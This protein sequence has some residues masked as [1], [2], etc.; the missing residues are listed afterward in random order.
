MSASATGAVLLLD[1]PDAHLEVLRQRQIYQILAQTAAETQ[2][3]IIAASHS[4]VILNEAA[5][6]D[7]VVAFIGK[8]HRIDDRGK[9]LVKAL[10]EIGFEQYVQA[11]QA[12]WVLYL[13]GSTD[14]AILQA[15]A[16]K[17]EHPARAVLERPFAH[18][19]A[20]QPGQA[21]HHFY[22]LRE[23]KPDLAGIALYDRLDLN[24]LPDPELSQQMWR[25]RE[26]ESYLC[27]RSTLVNFAKSKGA[28]QQGDLFAPLWVEAME[29]SIT[30]IAAALSSLGKADP[31]GPDLKVSDDFLRPLF[32]KFYS[33][34]K[35]PDLLRKTD[36][37]TLAP[38][39]L[40][41]EVDPEVGEK[42]DAIAAVASKAR[43]RG[44]EE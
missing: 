22:A 26:I 13:E 15:F 28:E 25:R 21:R 27:H 29:E 18:Y 31:W 6:R 19:V 4:E 43:P 9:Q 3:Q 12:G 32:Q 17:L 16:E 14:L 36:Y 5:D 41:A 39:V 23:A 11:E 34:L 33:K 20:N 24:L 2:S 10:K 1:E 37:H 7:M 44:A 40:P 8:P 30:E 35:L 42:L 38:F